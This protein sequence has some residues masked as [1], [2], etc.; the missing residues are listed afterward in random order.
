MPRKIRQLVI[1]RWLP[2]ARNCFLFMTY[3]L[4]PYEPFEPR[5]TYYTGTEGVIQCGI[6][7]SSVSDPDPWNGFIIMTLLILSK[8]QGK[9][10][11]KYK[12]LNFRILIYTLK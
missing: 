3:F 1:S 8:T 12:Y 11:K 9:L 4:N 6:E 2:S 5:E 7:R 10:S